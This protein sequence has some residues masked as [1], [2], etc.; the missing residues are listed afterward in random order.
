MKYFQ[1]ERVSFRGLGIAE[2]LGNF[3]L[4]VLYFD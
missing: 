2:K 4:T 1:F 3:Q